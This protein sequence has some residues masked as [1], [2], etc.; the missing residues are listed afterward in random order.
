[1][2]R[3]RRRFFSDRFRLDCSGCRCA[4]I[5]PFS[6]GG[7]NRLR[8]RRSNNRSARL[9]RC[10]RNL[11]SL[12]CLCCFY[13]L[14]QL[15][16]RSGFCLFSGLGTGA[17]RRTP[18]FCRRL[19]FRCVRF[20]SRCLFRLRFPS[21]A[22]ALDRRLVGK[23][24]EL[25]ARLRQFL[26]TRAACARFL[27]CGLSLV[28]LLGALSFG[29]SLRLDRSLTRLADAFDGAR[30]RIGVERLFKL[31]VFGLETHADQLF[32]TNKVSLQNGRQ[33]AHA[34]SFRIRLRSGTR[35]KYANTTN[36]RR[37]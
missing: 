26:G 23:K 18:R 22:C 37:L 21:R 7:R 35:V 28:L 14:S 29:C 9:G 34:A 13:R 4:N 25:F 17:R 11:F 2:R 32:S 15:L 24:I 19:R 3:N 31:V 12:G 30:R 8:H 27:D 1:M 6:L 16:H 5:H 20:F 36:R 33:N 10:R